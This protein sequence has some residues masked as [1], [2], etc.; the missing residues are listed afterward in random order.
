M[1][2]PGPSLRAQKGRC[3]Q[4]RYSALGTAT[5]R[6]AAD[7]KPQRSPRPQGAH[8]KRHHWGLLAGSESVSASSRAD[9]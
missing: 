2:T 7:G 1:L 4:P 8:S 3:Q 9:T 6:D 5:P